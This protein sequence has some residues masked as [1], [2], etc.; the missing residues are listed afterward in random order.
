M[1]K[2]E[3]EDNKR[4]PFIGMLEFREPIAKYSSSSS[5]VCHNAKPEAT[6][7]MSIWRVEN[8]SSS[9][10]IRRFERVSMPFAYL[11]DVLRHKKRSFG[12]RRRAGAENEKCT[13]LYAHLILQERKRVP[14]ALYSAYLIYRLPFI[15]HPSLTTP[16]GIFIT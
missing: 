15:T 14:F 1:A 4:S 5:P 2:A 10:S 13:G 3:P 16:L 11:S 9:S 7:E 12:S 8:V 6:N